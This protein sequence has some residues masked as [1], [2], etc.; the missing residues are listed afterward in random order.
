MTFQIGNSNKMPSVYRGLLIETSTSHP[1]S[2]MLKQKNERSCYIT[3][4][5]CGIQLA[6][7]KC[8]SVRQKGESKDILENDLLCLDN[9]VLKRIS[10]DSL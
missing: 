4:I 3:K 6:P 2:L 5:R 8:G 1:K 7:K 10:A 9:K